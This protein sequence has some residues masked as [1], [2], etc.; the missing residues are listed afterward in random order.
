MKSF[1]KSINI[2][3]L[4]MDFFRKGTSDSAKPF[5]RNRL[6]LGAMHFQ[7]VTTLTLR[8]YKGMEYTVPPPMVA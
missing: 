3:E 5:H 6:F 4:M 8:E 7:D 2:T 1:P